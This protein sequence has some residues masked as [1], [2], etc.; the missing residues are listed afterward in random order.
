MTKTRRTRKLYTEGYWPQLDVPEFREGVQPFGYTVHFIAQDRIDWYH[1]ISGRI[2]DTREDAQAEVIRK[3][4][5]YAN[6]G[7]CVTWCIKPLY[8]MTPE[9]SAAFMARLRRKPVEVSHD[10]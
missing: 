4:E 10:E 3:I 1:N 6:Q 5:H 8:P 9:E 2:H 7:A